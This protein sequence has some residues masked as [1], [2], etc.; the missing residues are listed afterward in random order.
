MLLI[1]YGEIHLKGQNRPFFEKVLLH[2]IIASA[3]KFGGYVDKGQGRYYLRKVEPH[4]MSQAIDAM[5][6]IFGIYSVSPAVEME[7]DL[8]I[9][10]QAAANA[11]R[12]KLK[13]L[14]KETATFKVDS[15]RADKHFPMNSMTLSA[16]AGGYILQQVPGLSVDVHHPDFTVYIEIRESAFVYTDIVMGS[17]GMPVGTSGKGMLLLSGGIDSPVAGY[18]MAKR[19]IAL[20]AVH[21]H[22]FPYTSERAKQKVIELAQELSAYT[23]P[24][25]IHMVHFTDIQMAIYEK[26]P[27]E[28]LTLI[29]RVFMMRIAEKIAK[30][31]NCGALITGESLGQVA[32]QTLAS[33][34]VTNSVI[35]LPVFRPLI[36]M[37]KLEIMEIAKRIETYETSILPYEDC[38]TVFVPK[39][40]VTHP[41]LEKILK[42]VK[43][44]DAEALI[45]DALAKTEVITVSPASVESASV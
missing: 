11:A 9:I 28:Q 43:L 13:A 10:F 18:M 33:L 5:T 2:A 1:R 42:S 35:D 27:E 4:D 6:K 26:C 44:L 16:E 34:A 19:G 39:Q 31:R 24:I 23:G 40:P 17:G 38:C 30:D 8:E 36:G 15:K 37:D 20:E 29:M 14:G 12:S 45:A 22:S 41:K 21:Y 32:S 25:K 3:K 7:K